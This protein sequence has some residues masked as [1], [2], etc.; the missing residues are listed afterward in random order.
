MDPSPIQ[1]RFDF[2]SDLIQEA[3]ALTLHYFQR[4]DT[5]NLKI[6]G[7]QDTASEADVNT[8]ALIRERLKSRFPEDAFL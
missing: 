6:K 8:E 7:P 4:L 2:A 5:L 3:G 1:E